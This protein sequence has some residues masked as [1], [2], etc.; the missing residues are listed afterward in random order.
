MWIVYE[1]HW[2]DAG[3]F[4]V[5]D[6]GQGRLLMTEWGRGGND[7]WGEFEGFAVTVEAAGSVRR[8]DTVMASAG[9]N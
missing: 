6:G 5:D 2:L 8:G 3:H 7:A 1:N 9:W 4:A